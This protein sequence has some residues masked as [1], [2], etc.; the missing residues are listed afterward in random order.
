MVPI[1]SYRVRLAGRLWLGL[2]TGLDCLVFIILNY[3]VI[4]VSQSQP[5]GYSARNDCQCGN[6]NQNPG[7]WFA[8][9]R[10]EIGVTG[11]GG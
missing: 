10:S 5:Q 8:V 11:L 7:P 6:R 9:P 2:K 4:G 1:G 3:Q